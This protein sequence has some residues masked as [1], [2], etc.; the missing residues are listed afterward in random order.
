M[1]IRIVTK[2][3]NRAKRFDRSFVSV[4]RLRAMNKQVET[5]RSLEDRIGLRIIAN[6]LRGHC[7]VICRL[8][9]EDGLVH[10]IE[11]RNHGSND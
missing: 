2:H 10:A 5:R 6:L 11:F 1:T 4:A 8:S 9:S 3:N 7:S